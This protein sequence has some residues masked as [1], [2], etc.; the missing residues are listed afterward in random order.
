[1]TPTLRRL[2]QSERWLWFTWRGWLAALAAIG[3]LYAAVMLSPLGFRPTV[4]IALLALTTLGMLL[5]GLSGQA[6]APERY[7]LALI[8]Y[9]RSAKVF[10]CPQQPDRHGLV[11]DEIPDSDTDQQ[12]PSAS[13]VPE[14]ANA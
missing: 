8:R 5:W 9:R 2:G 11:L 6:L 7:L 14:G 3:I 4:T 13:P 12:P 10:V 1:M